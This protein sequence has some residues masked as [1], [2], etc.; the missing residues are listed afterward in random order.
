MGSLYRKRPKAGVGGAASKAQF[1]S[2]F[3][4]EPARQIGANCGSA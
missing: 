4:L 1:V 2:Q 3:S